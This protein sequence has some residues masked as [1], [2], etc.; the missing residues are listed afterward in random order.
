M[1]IG[2]ISDTHGP[3]PIDVLDRLMDCEQVL[4]AGDIGSVE[5]F[6]QV[7]S[8]KRL[9]W[10]WGNIDDHVIRSETSPFDV[11]SVEDV[12]I[13]MLHIGGYPGRYSQN[14]IRLIE[15]HKP[16]LFISGHSHILKIMRDRT[17]NLIHMNPGA[18]GYKGFHA[19]R[20][21]ILFEVDKGVI[22]NVQVVELAD[23]HKPGLDS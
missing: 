9:H 6:D 21:F 11:F 17:R 2:L 7:P 5:A 15:E 3:I 12:R 20:T 4:H 23:R 18:C 14:A 16:D 19:K 1:K 10:V 8:E 22:N 13:L